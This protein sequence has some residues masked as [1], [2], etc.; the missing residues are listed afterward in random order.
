MKSS[1]NLSQDRFA[2]L[3]ETDLQ[4]Q[5]VDYDKAFE[6]RCRDLIV[7]N[8]EFGHCSVPVKYSGNPSLGKWCSTMRFTYKRNQKGMKADYNLSQDRIDRLEE[9]GFQWQRYNR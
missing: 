1:Y 3:E 9:N 2:R 5:G 8:E 7:F 6:K 4:W